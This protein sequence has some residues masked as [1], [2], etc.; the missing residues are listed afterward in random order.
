MWAGMATGAVDGQKLLDPHA[1]GALFG[2]A[3]SGTSLDST[4]IYFND[5]NAN[6]V[7]VLS[8]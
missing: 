4:L 8:L 2:I 5:D 7:E 6:A 1:P 3:A